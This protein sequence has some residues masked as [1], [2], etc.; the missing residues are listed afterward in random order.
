LVERIEDESYVALA[1]PE[2]YVGWSV[3]TSRETASRIRGYLAS[4]AT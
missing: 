3:A 1:A 4:L 2:D